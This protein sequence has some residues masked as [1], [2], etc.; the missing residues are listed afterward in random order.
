MKLLDSERL[1][2]ELHTGKGQL[3]LT[4]HRVCHSS[5]GEFT[6]IMLENVCSVAVARLAH[7]GLLWIV[8]MFMA[9]A[10]YLV[11]MAL[12][13]D[14]AVPEQAYRAVASFLLFVSAILVIAFTLT[15]YSRVQVASAGASIEFRVRSRIA[16]DVRQFVRETEG[17]QNA[18]FLELGRM[19][20]AASTG[21]LP[22][23]GTASSPD[24]QRRIG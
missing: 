16:K 11:W 18:R 19:A 6:S 12:R 22:A 23:Q 1:L 13:P 21:T 10:G 14:T 17:A 4:T 5:E 15:R 24:R 7:R 20:P 8:G 3:A 9:V 2:F